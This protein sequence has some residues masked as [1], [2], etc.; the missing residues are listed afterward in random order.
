M[1]INKKAVILGAISFFGLGLMSFISVKKT[2]LKDVMQF[3]KVRLTSVHKFS[4]NL[5]RLRFEVNLELTNPTRHN[6]SVKTYGIVR[7]KVYRIIRNGRILATGSLQS[8]SELNL[9]A[10]GSFTFRNLEVILPI[11]EVI[12]QGGDIFT[13]GIKDLVQLWETKDFSAIEERAKAVANELVYEI[14]LETKGSVVTISDKI[15]KK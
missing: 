9:P 14:D 13:G 11:Q 4:I 6:V 5:N 15:I 2:Q 12:R 10:G 1:K 3:L 8:V 7:P